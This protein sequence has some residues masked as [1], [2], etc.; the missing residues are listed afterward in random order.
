MSIEITSVAKKS[1][2]ISEAATAVFVLNREDIRRAG[3]ENI[4][5]LL[6]QV[7]GV[8][9]ARIDASR[10]AVSIRGFSNRF[11]GK[12]LVL[13]DGRTLYSPLFSGVYWEAQDVLLEDVERIEVIRGPGATV[14][15]AN[16]VN[17]VIN[18]ITRNTQDSQGTYLQALAGDHQQ[19][20]AA[21]YGQPVGGSGTYRVYAKLDRHQPLE[22]ATGDEAFDAWDQRRAGFRTD[23]LT[24]AAD[25]VTLQAD[26]YRMQADQTLGVSSLSPVAATSFLPNT[27]ELSGGN[28]QLRWQRQTADGENLSLQA[29]V[30]RAELKDAVLDQRIDTVDVEFQHRIRISER[31][32]L[33]WGLG[34]RQV[35]DELVGSF[36]ISFDPQR[37]TT[38]LFSVFLQ[39]EITLREDLHLTLGSKFEQN[40]FTGSEH[41]PSIRLLWQVSDKDNIWGAISRAV[42]TPSR[43]DHDSALNYLVFPAFSPPFFSANPTVLGYRGTSDYVSEEVVTTELGYRGQ[44]S[45]KL[46]L[47]ATAFYN[48]YDKLRSREAGAFIP[49]AGPIPYDL[50]TN[51]YGNLLQGVSYGFELAANLQMSPQ[52]RVRGSYSRLAMDLALKSG[53][54]DNTGTTVS[55]SE[56]SSPRHMAQL[57]SLYDLGNKLEL[58]AHFYYV[59]ELPALDVE[60]Y[61]RLDLRLGWQPVEDM[62]ISIAVQNLL[63]SRHLEYDA[64][65]VTASQVPR[66]VYAKLSWQF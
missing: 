21:R 53:S 27:A 9:V 50:L 25:T 51:V 13:L 18:I 57:H 64:V 4:P 60:D 12:L 24:R 46:N 3:V 48:D 26:T 45:E 42:S 34:Y 8:Q 7:P 43:A 47:D 28:L 31:H 17:G 1:Q 22:T 65:D 5:E 61:T 16:A 30:D 38:D 59:D 37:Q 6:R 23:W 41:Q 19:G 36:T 39:D 56:D 20:L 66:M 14:W 49:A 52:W 2:R 62:E 10:Y 63:E 11:A 44:L 32:E 15:G 55:D 40:D 58:D 54:T 29:F 33:N 35:S